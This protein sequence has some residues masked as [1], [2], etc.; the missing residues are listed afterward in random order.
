MT[1]PNVNTVASAQT[2]F[3][4]LALAG[5]TAQTM[6]SVE[7]A[8]LTGKRHDNVMADISKMLKELG[9]NA[10][11]FSGTQKYGKNNTRKVF[12]LPKRECLI[13][14]SGYSVDL[15]ARIIDRWQELENQQKS[16]QLPDFTNPAVAARAWADQVEAKQVLA[17]EN[18]K[19]TGAVE[20][21]QPK[22]DGFDRIANAD[23][24]MTISDAAKQLNIKPRA[25]FAWLEAH[26]WIFKRGTGKGDWVPHQSKINAGLLINITGTYDKKNGE[27]HSY[28]QARVTAK[29]LTKLSS[30]F[31]KEEESQREALIAELSEK[32][33]TLT[34]DEIDRINTDALEKASKREAVMKKASLLTNQEAKAADAMLIFSRL[35]TEDKKSILILAK[36]LQAVEKMGVAA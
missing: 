26:K 7:I 8:E 33:E 28:S 24:T 36:G 29:G 25:M 23:G 18:Q 22:A 32:L 5:S 17:I 9:I 34:P 1:T 35:S 31:N 16:P 12:N 30:L 10:P 15:R 6:S 14:V 13:L 4:P 3:H 2:D 11:E 20:K 21:L 27:K 19:L